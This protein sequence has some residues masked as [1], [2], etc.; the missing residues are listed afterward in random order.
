MNQTD[1]KFKVCIRCSYT[2]EQTPIS[3]QLHQ[4]KVNTWFPRDKWYD[5]KLWL[6]VVN[7][8]FNKERNVTLKQFTVFQPTKK[9]GP[10][11]QRKLLKSTIMQSSESGKEGVTIRPFDEL[12][13]TQGSVLGVGTTVIFLLFFF[14]RIGNLTMKCHHE[15]RITSKRR[16]KAAKQRL[17]RHQIDADRKIVKFHRITNKWQ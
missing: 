11:V 7:E 1:D 8:S 16:T 14:C 2:D 9:W 4:S 10:I 13:G 6:R 17:I 5:V 3:Q 12:T 15:P